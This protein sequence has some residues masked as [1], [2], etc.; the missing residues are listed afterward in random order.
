MHRGQYHV[1]YTAIDAIK[2][3]GYCE[4]DV[5][6]AANECKKPAD[7]DQGKAYVHFT[8]AM[9]AYFSLDRSTPLDQT[10]SV[11]TTYPLSFAM[12]LTSLSSDRF[13]TRA[14]GW[15]DRIELP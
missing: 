7:P 13:S 12:I 14:T 8:E 1:V 6:V 15:F 5:Y 9:E 2:N 10:M 4:F 11:L 3:Q